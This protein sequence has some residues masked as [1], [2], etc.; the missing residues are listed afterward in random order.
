MP[1]FKVELTI[2]E[3][4]KHEM[5]IEADSEEEAIQMVEDDYYGIDVEECEFD[6]KEIEIDYIEEAV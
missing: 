1:K 3:T 5:I 6:N 2:T 4:F